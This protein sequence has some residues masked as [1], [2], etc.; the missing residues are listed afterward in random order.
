MAKLRGT[1]TEHLDEHRTTV[2]RLGEAIAEAGAAATCRRAYDALTRAAELYGELEEHFYGLTEDEKLR[3]AKE[4]DLW[5]ET[6]WGEWEE[7]I[8]RCAR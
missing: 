1:P 8:G 5:G 7:F 6:V 4:T 3:H 2:Q